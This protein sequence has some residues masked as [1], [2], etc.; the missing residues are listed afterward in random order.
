MQKKGSAMTFSLAE[1]VHLAMQLT[2]ELHGKR[3]GTGA[4]LPRA[5]TL[6][7]NGFVNVSD[8]EFAAAVA[9]TQVGAASAEGLWLTVPLAPD[10]YLLLGEGV[11]ALRYH[12]PGAP[13]DARDLHMRLDFDD[14]SCLTESV[15]GM[16]FIRIAHG[17]DWRTARYPGQLG[18]SPL[19][20]AQFTVEALGAALA[21]N[22]TK[23]ARIALIDQARV[24]GLTNAYLNDIF[25]TARVHPAR[26]AKTLAADELAR[27]HES[28]AF[29]MRRAV[30]LGGDERQRD[31][32]GAPGGYRFV[33]G[34]QVL[35]APCPRC[36]AAIVK[37][38][39][40][41]AA[42]YLCPVC[43]PER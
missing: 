20:D 1:A 21:P 6:R 39:V 18:I 14:G 26:R 38:Q 27:L 41:A 13:V 10:T 8:E 11:G 15:A 33:M 40:G 2:R 31:L 43:Q 29:V 9:S 25:F 5:E 16:G 23:A 32:Y 28:I 42:A 19:D 34:R 36:G 4:L 35:G 17:E 37:V 7:R 12:P 30:S 22:G 3:V 24:A